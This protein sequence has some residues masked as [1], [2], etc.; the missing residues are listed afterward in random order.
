MRELIKTLLG[1]IVRK[2]A[3]DFK[4]GVLVE[5]PGNKE[6]GDYTTNI[7][8][9][10]TKILRKSLQEITKNLVDELEKQKISDFS[11]IESK[12]GFINFFLSPEYLYRS[13]EHT[14][15]SFFHSSK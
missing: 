4:G 8:F 3:L 15:S 10:L 1:D 9:A 2:I 7:A 13:S 11:K 6:H 14:T 5:V 12:N